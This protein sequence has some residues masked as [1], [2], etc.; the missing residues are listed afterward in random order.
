VTSIRL[1]RAAKR[2]QVRAWERTAK[3]CSSCGRKDQITKNKEGV[4]HS[5]G[6]DG[7][8]VECEGAAVRDRKARRR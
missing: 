7:V 4:T 8:C 6:R 1:F 2:S 5:V 3:R